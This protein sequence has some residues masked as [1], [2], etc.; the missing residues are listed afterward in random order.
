M[1]WKPNGLTAKGHTQYAC[2]RRNKDPEGNPGCGKTKVVFP[3]GEEPPA[4]VKLPRKER[5]RL[6]RER[7]WAEAV[8]MGVATPKR[9]RPWPSKTIGC[10]N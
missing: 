6:N 8:A 5:D 9:G 10:G 1:L 3:L 2:R 7:K 4:K